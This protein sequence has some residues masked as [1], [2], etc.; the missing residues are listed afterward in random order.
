MKL[1]WGIQGMT[2]KIYSADEPSAHVHYCDHALSVVSSI[3][4][5]CQLFTFSTSSQKLLKRIQVNLTKSKIST[6]STN[7]K[8]D[9]RCIKLCFRVGRK[10][11]DRFL[12]TDTFSNSSL[13]LLNRIQR[14]DLSVLY[15]VCV[16]R[17]HQ[18]TKIATVRSINNGCTLYSGARYVALW[19]TCLYGS[20][21]KKNGR[22][23]AS[24][25]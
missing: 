18:K 23:T 5:R 3:I 9:L 22:Y 16:F 6:S 13:K 4:H 10:N 12:L 25:A 20:L 14:K 11:Q 19:P 21:L 24:C 15:Q 8:R 7:I 2:E 17:A 1:G